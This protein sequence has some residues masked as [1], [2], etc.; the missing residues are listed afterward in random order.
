MSYA[1]IVAWS[2]YQSWRVTNPA[3]IMLIGCQVIPASSERQNVTRTTLAAA[4]ALILGTG[5]AYADMTTILISGRWAAFGG[6]GEDGVTPGCGISSY[7]PVDQRSLLVKWFKGQQTVGIELYKPSWAIP[8]GVQID[9]VLRVDGAEPLT[10]KGV[11]VGDSGTGAGIRIWV[12]PQ[13]LTSFTAQMRYGY[14]L[15]VSFPA[16]TEPPWVFSLIGSN[17]AITA[18]VG[19]IDYWNHQ[20]GPQPYSGLPTQPYVMPQPAPHAAPQPA[21]VPAAQTGLLHPI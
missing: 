1:G 19:C 7:M 16:G 15:V 11:S 21:P 4:L 3:T 13:V 18:M 12:S 20:T 6:Y 17:G 8:K 5:L 2:G 9:M 10:G 14:Q